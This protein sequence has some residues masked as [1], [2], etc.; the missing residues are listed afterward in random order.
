M[1]QIV[2]NW[3][4]LTGTVRAITESTK[5]A[6]HRT[7]FIEVEV[8]ADVEGFPNLVDA[9]AG[10]VVRVIARQDAL[11]G[12]GVTERSHVCCRVRK[13]TPFE[14]FVHPEGFTVVPADD[15]PDHEL[16]LER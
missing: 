3:A 4:E 16:P 6:E 13:A 10:D 12:A 7:V 5:G 1:V 15:D 9:A 11:D 2:E 14:I 8:V